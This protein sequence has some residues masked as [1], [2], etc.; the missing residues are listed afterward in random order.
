MWILFKFNPISGYSKTFALIQDLFIFLNRFS[1]K[2]CD[3]AFVINMNQLLKYILKTLNSLFSV[4]EWIGN[5]FS[6]KNK[7]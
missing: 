4:I 6:Q 2:F 7:K 3:T 5:N 1:I